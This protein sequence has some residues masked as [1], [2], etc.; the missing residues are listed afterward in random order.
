[1]RILLLVAC[2]LG[3]LAEGRVWGGSLARGLAATRVAAILLFPSLALHPA[4][5]AAAAQVAMDKGDLRRLVR[6]LQEVEFLLAHWDEKT[7]Y[8]NFAEFK[9][10]LLLPENKKALLQAAASTGLLDYDKSATMNVRCR[11]DPEVVRAFLGLTSDNLLLTQAEGL[12]LR[13][14]SVERV[15]PDVIDT[16][17]EAV[18]KYSR[19]VSSVDALGYSVRSGLGGTDARTLAE[20]LADGKLTQSKAAVEEARDGLKTVVELLHIS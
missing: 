13:P 9:R 17:Q 7:V 1:M 10:E 8:C 14:S 4:P 19:A 18:E 16:Y 3:P 2:W 20:T 15:D 11:A 5:A 12:M 6:G